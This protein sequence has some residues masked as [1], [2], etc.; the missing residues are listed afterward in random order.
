MSKNLRLVV[1]VL[2]VAFHLAC[3]L[4]WMQFR[5][6]GGEWLVAIGM[7]LS[8]AQ[9]NLIAVWAA[10]APG[11]LMVRLPWAL[12][13][14]VLMWYALVLGQSY[15]LDESGWVLSQ[16]LSRQN[17]VVL[18]LMILFGTLSIQVP[19]W[20]ANY[21]FG[22][23]LVTDEGESDKLSE[24]QFRVS[25]LLTAM[26]LLSVVLGLS[27]VVLPAGRVENMGDGFWVFFSLLLPV[28]A[29]CNLL[30]TSPCIW[31]AFA[32]WN[33]IGIWIVAWVTFAILLTFVEVGVLVA[34]FGGFH[35]PELLLMMCVLNLTQCFTVWGTLL[36]LRLVGFRLVRQKKAATI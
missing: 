26:F 11:R 4:A 10:L 8:I 3:D 5:R 20:I 17:A 35:E 7:G 16:A 33:R 31:T 22:W 25:H 34:M 6:T 30:V 1:I 23:R 9:V 29:S 15:Q 18:G 24:R 32:P 12:F 2:L 36:P 14:G 27:R 28:V 13:M 21:G 19:L